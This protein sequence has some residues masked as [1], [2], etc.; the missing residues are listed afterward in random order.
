MEEDII[1]P[2]EEIVQSRPR[3]Q[4]LMDR[5]YV[6]RKTSDFFLILNIGVKCTKALLWENQQDHSHYRPLCSPSTCE[7]QFF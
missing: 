5:E 2:E 1:S 6:T 4:N 3:R 7:N